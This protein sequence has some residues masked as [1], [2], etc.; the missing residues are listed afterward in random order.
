MA[1]PHPAL[2]ALASGAE[3]GTIR[4]PGALLASALDH[5]MTGLLFTWARTR[6]DTDPV[7]LEALEQEDLANRVWHQRLWRTLSVVAGDLAA[8]GVEVA[9]IKGVTCEARWYGRLGER[10]CA[11]VDLLV[12]PADSR[13]AEEILSVLDPG[14]PL[15]SVITELVGRGRLQAIAVQVEGVSVDVHF[16]LLQLGIPFRHG[17]EAWRRTLPFPLP[18][19]GSVPVLDAETTLVELLVNLH[20]DRFHHLLGFVDIARILCSEDLDWELV[21]GIVRAEGLD[22]PA[23]LALEAVCTTLGIPVPRPADS[24]GWRP[25]L[26]RALWPPEVR[27]QGRLGSTG[28]RHRQHLLPVLARRRSWEA[29]LHLGRLAFPAPALVR[30]AYSSE[31][32]SYLRQIT[33]DRLRRMVRLHHVATDAR[34][35]QQREVVPIPSAAARRSSYRSRQSRAA[36]PGS[37]VPVP[38]PSVIA[39]DVDGTT[40]LVGGSENARCKLG[41]V[42]AVIWEC[43]DGCGTIDQIAADLCVEFRADAD[44]V[45]DDVLDIAFEL[46]MLGLLTLAGGPAAL[47]QGVSGQLSDEPDDIGPHSL[48]VGAEGVAQVGGDLVD[49]APTVDAAPHHRRNGAEPEDRAGGFSE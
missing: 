48:E 17:E 30:Y 19:G 37:V 22:V 44:Q 43:F 24:R 32:G 23:L 15:R 33:G 14:H 28:A 49:R 35:Q 27:L 8:I 5:R 31:E 13:R 12:A 25:Q 11:D 20:R 26:W 46:Q 18:G 9:A 38:R 29:A 34:R 47:E 4:D 1:A 16:D 3:P 42:A 45:R 6:T 2:V 39:L 10:P 41:P 21:H 40:V 36:V 7:W